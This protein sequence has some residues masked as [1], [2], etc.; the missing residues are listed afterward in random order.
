MAREELAQSIDSDMLTFM[1]GQFVS[2]STG[3]M[4]DD[5]DKALRTEMGAWP[6]KYWK[7]F[8][9]SVRILVADFLKGRIDETNFNNSLS[10]TL[11]VLQTPDPSRRAEQETIRPYGSFSCLLNKC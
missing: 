3:R 1:V 2:F 10:L 7:F 8:P 9:Q 11:Q 5:E 4:K 6:E